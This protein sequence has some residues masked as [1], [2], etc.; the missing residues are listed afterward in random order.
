MITGLQA[1]SSQK[2][3]IAAI[4][5]AQAQ[6]QPSPDVP[7]TASDNLAPHEIRTVVDGLNK[8]MQTFSTD[9][10]FS[11]DASTKQVVVTVTDKNTHQVIR[12]IPSEEMLRVSQHIAQLLGIVY[13]HEG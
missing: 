7:P 12:Q 4:A 1:V 9:L 2:V 5:T 13:D 11:I 8:V 10:E 3:V 6:R